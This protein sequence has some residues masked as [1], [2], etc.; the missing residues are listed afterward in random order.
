MNLLIPL[1][2]WY[3]DCYYINRDEVVKGW[4]VWCVRINLT[5]VAGSK[6]L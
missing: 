1:F 4:H 5:V 2:P 6:P 3:G